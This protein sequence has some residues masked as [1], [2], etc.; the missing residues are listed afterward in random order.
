MPSSGR[1]TKTQESGRQRLPDTALRSVIDP[2]STASR[3]MLKTKNV[4]TYSTKS[5]SRFTTAMPIELL[6]V[7]AQRSRSTAVT[8]SAQSSWSRQTADQRDLT[9]FFSKS[10]TPSS[11]TVTSSTAPTARHRNVTSTSTWR[12][13]ASGASKI[14]REDDSGRHRLPDVSLQSLM[15]ASKAAAASVCDKNAHKNN[16][17]SAAHSQPQPSECLDVVEVPL[18]RQV[19]PVPP[20][21]SLSSANN[22]N[23]PPPVHPPSAAHNLDLLLATLTLPLPLASVKNHP[24]RPDATSVTD[25]APA[26]TTMSSALSPIMRKRKLDEGPC[27]DAPTSFD[28]RHP[29][30]SSH[31]AKHRTLP[32]VSPPSVDSTMKLDERSFVTD[33]KTAPKG[34]SR[35]RGKGKEDSCLHV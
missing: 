28:N 12:E 33:D 8:S 3:A 17:G 18:A 20:A 9:P 31:R 22:A 2:Q 29:Y 34:K 25:S 30:D 21:Q 23:A 26:P 27:G 35:S 16:N 24:N 32:S 11:S 4:D 15:N 6:P 13:P 10:F 7:D 14:R 19:A 1:A 5:A